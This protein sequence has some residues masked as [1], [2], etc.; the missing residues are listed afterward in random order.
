MRI[1]HEDRVR[2]ERAHV[3][4]WPALNTAVVDGWLWRSSGGGSQRANSVST[5]DFIGGDVKTAID[6][7][8]Y[9]YRD[10]RMPARFQTFDET[11]PAALAD[12]LTARGYREGEQTATMF[13]QV[14]AGAPVA[15]VECQDHAS[16]EWL[17]VYLNAIS[18]DRRGVNQLI[19]ERIPTPRAFFGCRRDGRIVATA[20]C[21]AGHGCGVIECIATRAECRREG[22]ALAV[23]EALEAWAK[24][25]TVDLLGLQVVE[26]NS[27]A[28][29]LYQR[30]GFAGGA[31]NR[32]WVR[33]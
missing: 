1:T 3:R 23:L 13:K 4:A 32:F 5:I 27:A 33:G 6:T 17:E 22:A 8:E 28:V 21:V 9:R 20:L 26:T 7:V 25:Q 14:G 29:S 18:G 11:C 15:A 31:T 16:A 10:V 2:M 12:I 24:S 30:L 19:L